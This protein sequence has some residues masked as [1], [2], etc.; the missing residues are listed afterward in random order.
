[1]SISN[2]HKR[3]KSTRGL[4]FS[5]AVSQRVRFVYRAYLQGALA[6]G[7][8]WDLTPDQVLFLMDSNC[9]YCGKELS[10]TG[11]PDS[12][13]LI[14]QI[15][16]NGIDVIENDGG[17]TISNV[18]SCCGLCNSMQSNLAVSDFLQHVHRIAE[19]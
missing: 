4:S 1:M 5:L 18:V 19:Y 3:R 10:N 16:Y 6:R 15:P 7:R 8:V 12:V 11:F 17:Y 2:L 14:H 9:Y 13:M